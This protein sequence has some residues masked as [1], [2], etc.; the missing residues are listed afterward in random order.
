MQ[1]I[2]IHKKKSYLCGP[3]KKGNLLVQWE[4]DP[5]RLE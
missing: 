5:I 4:P 3:L 2:G 1:L